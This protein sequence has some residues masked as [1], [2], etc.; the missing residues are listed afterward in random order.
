MSVNEVVVGAQKRS[1]VRWIVAA[2]MWAAIAINFIDRTAV[3]VAA[4][5][6]MKELD[7]NTAE[8]GILMAGFF[9]TYAMLQIPAGYLADK[10]GQ[11]ITLGMSL[12]WWS[13]ATGMTGLAVGFK[14]LMGLRM[15]LGIGEAGAYPS[16]AAITTKWF[17][18]QERATIGGL[19][20]SGSKFGGAVGMPII[21]WLMLTLGWKEMFVVL[22]ALG[23][24]WAVV[25]FK[26]F[27]ERPED[28]PGVNAEE[29]EYIRSGQEAVVKKEMPM[30]WYQLLKYR[31]IWAMCIGFFMINYNSYFFITWLPTYLM[32]ERGLSLT[33][34]GLVAALPMICAV[35]VEVLAG[36]VSD[37]VHSSNKLSLTTT[38]KL[39]ICVG[40]GMASCIGFS[41][42]TDSLAATVVLLCIAKSGTVVAASQVW[43]LP[44]EVAPNNMTGIVAGIQNSVSNMGGVVGPIVTGFIVTY[45]GHF[46]YALVFSAFLIFVAM[47]NYIFLLKKVEQIKIN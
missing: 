17:P 35:V 30:K 16:N 25:W 38:R 31:N 10:F 45:T 39:F 19:F 46:Q 24:V 1:R 21:T 12:L 42:F 4:P 37:R 34:M 41:A 18:K 13:I 6:I 11:K 27:K 32:K 43:A 20:D 28:H 33:Q 3:S 14:S 29:L 44:G 15:F 5:H 47:I 8:M 2:M 36:Y 23:V 40:L 22:G 9:W 26:F 7:I